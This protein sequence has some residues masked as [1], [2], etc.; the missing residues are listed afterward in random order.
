MTHYVYIVKL[1]NSKD[2]FQSMLRVQIC[3]LLMSSCTLNSMASL[4]MTGIRHSIIMNSRYR[5]EAISTC[6]CR[7]SAVLRTKDGL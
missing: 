1:Q 7:H 6:C 2:I 5:T 3:V 4:V